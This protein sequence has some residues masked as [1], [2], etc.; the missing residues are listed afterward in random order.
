ML[1]NT[2]AAFG[3]HGYGDANADCDPFLRPRHV[4]SQRKRQS[5][6]FSHLILFQFFVVFGTRTLH[7]KSLFDVPLSRMR[8]VKAHDPRGVNSAHRN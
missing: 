2:V 1:V 5:G 8:G 3:A 4:V 6:G 7:S